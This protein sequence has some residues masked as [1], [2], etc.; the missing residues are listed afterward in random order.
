MVDYIDRATVKLALKSTEVTRDSLIDQAISAASEG[1][2][3]HTGRDVPGFSL[4][5]AVSARVY[6]TRGRIVPV[7]GEGEKLLLDEIGASAG[8]IVETGTAASGWTVVAATSYEVQPDNSIVKGKPITSLLLTSGCWPRGT[9]TRVRVTAKWGWPAVPKVVKQAALLQAVRLYGRKDS[10]EGV[11]G[12]AEW[13][14]VRLGRVDPD[15]AELVK[16]LVLT[17]IA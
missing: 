4:D 16:N 6:S 2:D 13:G 12:S 14:A 1:L 8:L 7:R 3:H 10:P 17:G 9:T 15:V 5:A 11:A